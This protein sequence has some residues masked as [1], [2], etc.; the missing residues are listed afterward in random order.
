LTLLDIEN[1]TDP[2]AKGVF[3][4]L[5]QTKS[6]MTETEKF[7]KAEELAK[8]YNQVTNKWV[9]DKD[10]IKGKV[11]LQDLIA[12]RNEVYGNFDALS[13]TQQQQYINKLLPAITKQV[14]KGSRD[15]KNPYVQGYK[16]FEE[17]VD[18]LP[19]GTVIDGQPLDEN[20][21]PRVKMAAWSKY[22]DAL[23][24]I[25]GR[26]NSQGQPL[27]YWDAIQEAKENFFPPE[28][29]ALK[30]GDKVTANGVLYTVTHK[31]LDTGEPDLEMVK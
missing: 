9:N 19:R 6:P 15:T 21:A 12:L 13:E 17:W 18:N 11:A 3:L 28:Y 2:T 7:M 26:K 23:D 5:Y 29:R 4:Q 24:G 10:P 31:D 20:V 14:K 1:M 22:I 25:E 30:V 27:T 16:A 8:K